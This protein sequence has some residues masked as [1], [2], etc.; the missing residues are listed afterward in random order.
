MRPVTPLAA[1]LALA[2]GASAC[3]SPP[4]AASFPVTF[5]ANPKQP[6][7]G[8]DIS[9]EGG[10]QLGATGSDGTLHVTLT[11]REGTTVP[12]RVQ[13]PDGYRPPA[14]M[15][16]LRLRHFT[17]LDPATAARGIEV[18]IDCPPAERMAALVV[19]A[20]HPDLPVVAQGREIARTNDAGVAHALLRLPPSSTFRVV[21]GTG[22]RPQLRP[23]NPETTLTLADADE[24]FVIDP[25]FQLA[26]VEPPPEPRRPPRRKKKRRKKKE[27]EGPRL[28]VRLE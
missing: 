8:V 6:L 5:T 25:G 16:V 26:K 27:P 12:F 18:T 11:G 2:L 10:K 20:G 3:D 19:R 23:Q 17:G 13:C 4:K 28:P 7:A 21:V 9:I 1:A 24:I 14:E 22:D 15:P